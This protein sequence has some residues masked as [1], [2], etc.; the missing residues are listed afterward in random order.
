MTLRI[1]LLVP[2]M[3]ALSIVASSQSKPEATDGK[4]RATE[5]ILHQGGRNMPGTRAD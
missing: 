2:T 1:S 5:P 4:G 3:W